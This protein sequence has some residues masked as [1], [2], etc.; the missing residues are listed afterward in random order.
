MM[1]KY[2]KISDYKIK[3]IVKHFC[4]DIEASKTS[5]LTGINRNTKPISKLT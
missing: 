5:E 2:A 1:I 3:K 4:V